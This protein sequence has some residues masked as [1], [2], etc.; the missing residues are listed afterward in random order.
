MA[1][2]AVDALSDDDTIDLH[3]EAADKG[4]AQDLARTL[5][6][7][8]KGKVDKK[9]PKA[10]STPKSKPKPTPKSPKKPPTMKR[11]AA[12][13]SSPAAPVMKRP[14]GKTKDPDFVSAGKSMYKKNKV[15]CVKLSGKEESMRNAAIEKAEIFGKEEPAPNSGKPEPLED[16]CNDD[17]EGEEEET[18]IQDDLV[19][20]A[21]YRLYW[22]EGGEVPD[23]YMVQV[24]MDDGSHHEIEEVSSSLDYRLPVLLRWLYNYQVHRVPGMD[25]V[26]N[27][28]LVFIVKEI[29][30]EH[31]PWCAT[32]T[33]FGIWEQQNVIFKFTM[34]TRN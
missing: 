30:I 33:C 12:S 29:N 16:T 6:A 5:R 9:L 14:A 23:D 8:A 2:A 19:E 10:K 25:V 4:I 21:G 3:P 15:W 31:E 26:A 7:Q 18:I 32:L 34:A 20:E 13:A 24:I 28:E 22:V 27:E 1:L 17:A 11:P